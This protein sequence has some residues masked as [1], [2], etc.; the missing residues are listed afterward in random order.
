M[1]ESAVNEHIRKQLPRIEIAAEGKKCE[2]T[3]ED[4]RKRDTTD[5]GKSEEEKEKIHPDI[6]DQESFD[7]G[8]K[9]FES[10]EERRPVE[11]P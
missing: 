5:V 8:R 1:H 11:P 2:Q 7:D 9:E 3:I 10:T 6:R 4:V